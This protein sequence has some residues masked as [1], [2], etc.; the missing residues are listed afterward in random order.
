[1]LGLYVSDHPL[2]GIEHI[3]AQ[4][5]DTEIS[6][7]REDEENTPQ[8]VTIA[9]L[10]TSL[11]RKTTK[12]GNLWAIATVED[13]GGS[14]EV[15]FFPQ[16]YQTVSTM[17]AP[18]TVVTVRGKVNRRDGET[19]IYAQEMT[20]PDVS[21]ATHEAVTITVPASRCTTALVEQL[22]EVLE[23]HS[24]PSNVRMTLTSPGREVRTQLDERWRVSPT[25]ALF[26]DLKA[27]LGPNCLNH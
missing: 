25:T 22:R 21:S 15:M 3:L 5:A 8:N 1:M 11:N 2:L 24:G 13:L 27:I 9:G 4:L 23:R 10:I 7:L 19:T 18:D 20:L 16:T 17:L 26:S 12:N 14:I 6:T